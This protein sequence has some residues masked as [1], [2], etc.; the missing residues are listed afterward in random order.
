MRGEFLLVAVVGDLDAAD[1]FHHEERPAGVG[2]AAVE[3]L[4]DVRMVHDGQRL[5][6][7]L[8][9]RDHLL[10]VHA[11]LDDLERDL[12]ADRLGLLGHVN[13][14]AAAFA[15]LLEEFV[16]ADAV[17]GLF[18]DGEDDGGLDCRLGRRLL[19]LGVPVHG[20]GVLLPIA[21]AGIK[22]NANRTFKLQ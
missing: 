10:G 17:A 6:L 16:A 12:A 7:R 9:A 5:P 3:H 4:G 20:C 1:Q 13:H 22:A 15:D 19:V 21:E 2:G 8:E 14:A 11:E 18:G